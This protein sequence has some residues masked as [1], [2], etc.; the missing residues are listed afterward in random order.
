[1]K[2][3]MQYHVLRLGVYFW[4]LWPAL[5]NGGFPADR[6]CVRIPLTFHSVQDI[7]S[8]SRQN[9]NCSLVWSCLVPSLTFSSKLASVIIAYLI[10]VACLLLS[11]VIASL[12][13]TS[14]AIASLIFYSSN[15]LGLICVKQVGLVCIS[16]CLKLA[17][18]LT[19]CT[20]K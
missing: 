6:A 17:L 19:G 8:R 14:L 4:S 2:R 15:R 9:K 20:Y 3:T 16:F 5:S 11:L 10:R 13:I 18:D 12:V 1:M 7:H